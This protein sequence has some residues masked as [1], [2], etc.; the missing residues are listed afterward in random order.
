MKNKYLITI[1]GLQVLGWDRNVTLS[2]L[3]DYKKDKDKYYISYN[4]YNEQNKEYDVTLLE[5]DA[6]N[7]VVFTSSG[8][9]GSH[10]VIERDQKNFSHL[11]TDMGDAI[12]GVRADRIRN[13][14]T[15][16]GGR[17]S[18]SYAM[19]INASELFHNN[20]DITVKEL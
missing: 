15:D 9:T 17:L 20:L 13:T 11:R 5:V 7:K 6:D 14:L 16:K 4:N 19:D 2:T 1:E 8:D 12:L 10:L 18:L 3:G